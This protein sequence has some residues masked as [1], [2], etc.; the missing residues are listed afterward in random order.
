MGPYGAVLQRFDFMW[1]S[2]QPTPLSTGHSLSAPP[3]D[4]SVEP[5]GPYPELVGCLMYLMTCTQPDLAYPLSLLARYVAPVHRAWG[6]CLEDE[7]QLCEAEIYAGA[8]AAHELRWLTYLQT[9]LGERPPSPPSLTKRIALCYFLMRDLQQRGQLRLAYIATQANTADVFTKALGSRDGGAG[10]AGGCGGSGGSGGTRLYHPSSDLFYMGPPNPPC[11][12][13]ALCA[14][15]TKSAAVSGAYAKHVVRLGRAA[16]FAHRAPLARGGFCPSHAPSAWRFLPVARPGR[17]AVSARRAPWACDLFY[18]GSPN[19]PCA[20]TAHC[21]AGAKSAAVS[22]AYAK[23]VMRPGRATVSAHRAPLARGGF[24]PSHAPS[25]WWFLPVARPGRV[26]VSARRAPPARDFGGGGRV[27]GGRRSGGGG[28]LH[29]QRPT[30]LLRH[31]ASNSPT[32]ASPFPPCCSNCSSGF[33]PAPRA[34]CP[35]APAPP[36][37]TPCS[38][39]PSIPSPNCVCSNLGGGGGGVRGRWHQQHHPPLL[40]FTATPAAVGGEGGE[41]GVVGVTGGAAAAA[42]RLPLCLPA[43]RA[44]VGGGGFG[45]A[46]PILTTESARVAASGQVSASCSCRLVTHQSLHWHHHLGHPSLQRLRSMHSCLLV[47]GLPRSLPLLPRLLVL[48]CTPRVEGRQCAAPHSSFPP[49]TAPRQTLH[50][51]VWGPAPISGPGQERYFLLVVD[52]FTCY[53]T[54]FPLQ[55][56]DDV[57][58]VLIPWIRTVCRQRSARV[59]QD[60][61]VMRL[62][63]DRGG[64]FSSRLF[65]KCCREEGITQSFTL[66]ASSQQNGLAERRIGLIGE[67]ACTSM[68]HAAAP[69]FMWPFA[70]RYA[71]H[72]LNLWPHVSQP[73][74]SHTLLCTGEVCDAS[75]FQVWGSLALIRNPPASKLSPHTVRCVFLGFP[76]GAIFWQVYH[77]AT[78]RIESSTM[79][80]LTTFGGLLWL[81]SLGCVS[82]HTPPPLVEPLEVSFGPAEGGDPAADNTTASRCPPRLETPHG[83]LPRPSSPPLQPVAVDSGAVGGGDYG[84]AGS[85][86]AERPSGCGSVTRGSRGIGAGGAGGSGAGGAGAGG[87]G[88]SGAGGSGTGGAGARGVLNGSSGGANPAGA[89]LG[90][91]ERPC[92]GGVEGNT[93]GA[94]A[95]R[96]RSPLAAPNA[97]PVARYLPRAPPVAHF[98]TI[99]RHPTCSRSPTVAVHSRSHT[100]GRSHN[101]TR[102]RTQP[103]E[104][105]NATACTAA[106]A[107]PHVARYRTQLHSTAL[108]CLV[109]HSTAFN[110]TDS[111]SN[112]LERTSQ[113]PYALVVPTYST[114]STSRILTIENSVRLLEH[115]TGK[116]VAPKDPGPLGASPSKV[117]EARFEK[118]QLAAN[119]W[120]ARDDATGLFDV[121]VKR[122][123]TP[124]TTSLGCLVL[125]FLFPDLPSFPRVADLI[126]HL[127]SLDAQLRSV[128]PDPALLTTNP[129]AMWMTLYLLST[130]L[131]DR[132]ATALLSSPPSSRGVPLRSLPL[133]TTRPLLPLHPRSQLLPLATKG[134][135]RV[136]RREEVVAVVGV[137]EG[138]AVEVVEGAVVEVVEGAVVGGAE[139]VVVV[140]AEGVGVVVEVEVE[141]VEEEVVGRPSSSSPSSS[142]PSSSRPSSSSTTSSST[143]SSLN[144]SGSRSSKA[145]ASRPS[146]S[147]GGRLDQGALSAAAAH[148]A[149][150]RVDRFCTP[151]ASTGCRLGRAEMASVAAPTLRVSAFRS[152]LTAT[153]PSLAPPALP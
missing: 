23:H 82:G 122:Y 130:C 3:S 83:F 95:V 143:S 112:V 116:L 21:A 64:E 120:A 134:A 76:T 59:W 141:A 2:P 146:S 67:V 27:L 45:V 26:A 25:A 71:V 57:R 77:P 90:G 85:G 69:Y 125:P 84:G 31:Q 148:P 121:V 128:A 126:Q 28:W 127:R 10:G 89:V 19:P 144:N 46:E 97:P 119:R 4:E 79:S 53:T 81:G 124:T 91:A 42:A 102:T 8:M 96:K 145:S 14:A 52:D 93:I 43:A 12:V 37:C 56:K 29:L 35:P 140:A 135:R 133:L 104:Q 63:S 99:K 33:C 113:Y 73:E 30:T 13:A 103:H 109:P 136:V 78:R 17:V 87:A 58:G 62:H 6:S 47:S 111:H 20:V 65:E 138:A 106:R 151:S 50:M 80:P 105:P 49:T 98:P 88:G 132:F 139:G 54:V 48:P 15:G 117:D 44:T 70:V 129:P 7:V 9:D 108:N 149:G 137:V 92:G 142:S 11:A 75:E 18:M 66:P 74:T 115:A 40:S 114:M 123:S 60:L 94:I 150:R 41:G 55:H 68:I 86:V 24:C 152:L 110:R 39:L 16:V 118:A 131:P 61:S 147:S 36:D 32:S 38:P 107:L 101:R 153:T 22:G 100:H 34:P 1:S 51:D 72:Q 5:S